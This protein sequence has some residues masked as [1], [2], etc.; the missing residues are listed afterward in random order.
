MNQKISFRPT[1][2]QK[3]TEYFMLHEQYLMNDILPFD[4]SIDANFDDDL[5]YFKSSKYRNTIIDFMTKGELNKIEVFF[6]MLGDINIGCC[7][8][9]IYH[10]ED[11]KCLLMDFWLFKEYRNQGLGKSVFDSL[12]ELV[13]QKG[14][15]YFSINCVVERAKKWW[16][17]LDF[18]DDGVDE[19]NTPLFKKTLTKLGDSKHINYT[20]ISPIIKQ[21]LKDQLGVWIDSHIHLDGCSLAAIHHNQVIGFISSFKK[22]YPAPLA[23]DFDLY[24]DVIQVHPDYR[25]QKNYVA[26]IEYSLAQ[27]YAYKSFKP[28][29]IYANQ[30]LVGFIMY[31]SPQEFDAEDDFDPSGNYYCIFRFIIDKKYQHLGYGKKAIQQLINTIKKDTTCHKIYMSIEPTNLVAKHLYEA[32]GFIAD[33]RIIDGEVVYLLEY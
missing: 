14:G 18:N 8:F 22:Y 11:H 23:D 16:L 26:S 9:I 10:S 28:L 33:G 7:K 27:A 17:S 2:V 20:L 25:H 32:L 31:D 21:Q 30:I 4:T 3:M 6:I 12:T 24:I 5:A 19:H 13:I 1:S 29:A 15:L